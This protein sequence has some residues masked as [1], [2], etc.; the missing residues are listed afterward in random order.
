MTRRRAGRWTPL[1]LKADPQKTGVIS[2][3]SVAARTVSL[4]S[5]AVISSPSR[6]FSN[7]SSLCSATGFE[8]VDPPVA[9]LRPEVFRN[10][11]LV[12]GRALALVVPHDGFH[13]DKVHNATEHVAFANRNLD[14]GRGHWPIAVRSSS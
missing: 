3:D 10:V 11:N 8:E 7:N 12:P 1:F 4:T 9:S 6:Y 14:R 13:P 5:S 2:S